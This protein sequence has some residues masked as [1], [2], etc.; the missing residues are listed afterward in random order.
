MGY[1]QKISSQKK[2]KGEH[3]AINGLCVF[4]H[5]VVHAS[6]SIAPL[7]PKVAGASAYST[8]CTNTL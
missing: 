7:N 6:Y 8:Y 5:D 1:K 3:Y 4:E 2:T